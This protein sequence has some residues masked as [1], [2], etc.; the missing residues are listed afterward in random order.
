M[1]DVVSVSDFVGWMQLTM[2]VNGDLREPDW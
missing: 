2:N 1:L